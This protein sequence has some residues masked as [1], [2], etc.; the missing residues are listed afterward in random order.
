LRLLEIPAQSTAG[1]L[2]LLRWPLLYVVILLALASLY[3]YGPSRTK[4]Q[5]RWVTWGSAISGGTWLLGS[6]LLSWY[7]TN[8][9]SYNA[10][11]GS[12]GAII[13]FM[14]WMWLSTTIVRA[15]STISDGRIGG[16]SA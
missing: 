4:P 8:F 14:V 7:V 2:T 3:R 6:L 1:L 15:G 11:Y 5:W 12:L 10:T 13:G 16:S 9:G